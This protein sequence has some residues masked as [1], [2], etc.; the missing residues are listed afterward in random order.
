MA[1]EHIGTALVFYGLALFEFGWLGLGKAHPRSAGLIALLCGLVGVIMSLLAYSANPGPATLALIFGITFTAAAIHLIYGL[2]LKALGWQLLFFG[3]ADALYVG[4]FAMN[5][6]LIFTVFA[7]FWFIVFIL[8]SLWSLTGKDVYG[9][10]G[11]YWALLN[12]FATTLIPGFIIAIG[13][14]RILLT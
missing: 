7:I 10:Y 1:L 8:F 4:L 5:G 12:A 14:E 6:L 11:G 2:D 9:R 3:I 13:M